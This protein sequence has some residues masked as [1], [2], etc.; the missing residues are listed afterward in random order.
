MNAVGRR[1]GLSRA[2]VPHSIRKA[3]SGRL[4]LGGNT[5]AIERNPECTETVC[6][7]C[8][9]RLCYEDGVCFCPAEYCGWKCSK[10]REE[11]EKKES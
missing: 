4:G 1:T 11:A 7:V 3:F 8:G 2:P 10:C 5:M 9:I 6:P